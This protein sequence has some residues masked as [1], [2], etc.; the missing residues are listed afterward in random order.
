MQKN[1]KKRDKN[2]RR[3]SRHPHI[4]GGE[5]AFDVFPQ[6]NQQK[7]FRS[8]TNVLK[9]KISDVESGIRTHVIK[10][11]IGLAVRRRTNW[12]ISTKK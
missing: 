2:G 1:L 10:K 12:A 4:L 5:P 9:K 11:I 3:N 8:T 7:I 6:K